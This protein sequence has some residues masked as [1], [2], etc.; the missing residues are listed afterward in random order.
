MTPTEINLEINKTVTKHES[1]K[2]DIKKLLD[3]IELSESQ[4]NEKLKE[5][6]ETEKKYVELIEKLNL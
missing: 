5:L 1:L 4:V 3:I 6:D 2:E